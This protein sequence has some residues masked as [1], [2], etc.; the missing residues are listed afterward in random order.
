MNT[1]HKNTVVASI[2]L[3]MTV[4]A[5]SGA[6]ALDIQFV[7]DEAAA[8]VLSTSFTDDYGTGSLAY[9]DSTGAS[10]IAYCVELEQDHASAAKG[11][12]TY[13]VGSFS[14]VQATALQGLYSSTYAS[15]STA[16]Q[17][18]AFQTAVW[19]ITHETSG[20]AFNVAPNSGAFFFTGLTDV[21]P[22]DASALNDAFAAQVNAYLLAATNYSG[23]ELY[24]ISKLSNSRYQDLVS[25]S[26]VPEPASYGLLAAGLLAV[27]FVARRRRQPD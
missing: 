12:Q 9:V 20:N 24:T 7:G 4:G 21:A 8:L 10:F 5:A 16:Q 13:T 14:G 2:A 1:F 17:Q 11:L 25:V 6:Q 23:A 15:I 19:E 22:A 27:G 26:P 3:L 18:A